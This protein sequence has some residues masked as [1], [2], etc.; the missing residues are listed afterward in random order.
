MMANFDE[1]LEKAKL[2]S[3]EKKPWHFHMLGKDCKFNDAKGKFAIVLEI[4]G[5]PPSICLF[6]EKPLEQ[7]LQCKDH[8]PNRQHFR[9]FGALAQ[10]TGPV[11]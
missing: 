3:K 4:E 6:D 7:S 11:E 10:R 2:L 5:A 9:Q 1:L 8:L